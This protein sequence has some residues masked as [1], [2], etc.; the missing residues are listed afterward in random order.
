MT[1]QTSLITD[2]QRFVL[3]L[4]RASMITGSEVY[5]P[6]TDGDARESLSIILRNGILLTVYPAIKKTE[7]EKSALLQRLNTDL[8]QQYFI[9]LK[10]TVLQDHEGNLALERLGDAGFQC[11]ALKGWEMK[12]FYPEPNMRQ[13]A[14]LDILV[15]PYDFKR[16]RTVMESLE[17]TADSESS[18]K[19]DSFRKGE[20]HIEM[21]KRLT[22]DSSEIQKW[23]RGMWSRAVRAKENI[24]KMSPEDYYIFHFVHLHKDF[25]NGSLG[26]RRIVDTWLLQK[27]SIDMETVKVNLERFG[28]W[29]FHKRMVHLSHATMGDEPID[30]DSEVL[31]AHAFRHGIYGSGISYKAGR[32]AAMGKDLKSGKRISLMKAVFLPYKR[33]KAQ[34]PILEKYPILLPWC[35]I[36][37]IVH[38]LRGDMK[39][40]RAKLDYSGIKEEDFQEMK[41]F[42]KAGGVR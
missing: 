29:T 4:L 15:R 37:R 21:H 23:E 30:E 26:L 2:E 3:S 14:D 24:Y 39:K 19:H 16:I 6:E 18:W 40:N 27:Q 42:F 20:V 28:L 13:M 36:K 5:V 7:G 17:Y 35:W 31:L 11:I 8:R 32:I 1:E 34:F 38:F 12:T 10:Q 33:M 41:R 25:M 9:T 22:D